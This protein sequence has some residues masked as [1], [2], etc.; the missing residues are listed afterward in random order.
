M[1]VADS[2]MSLAA[3]GMFA[4]KWTQRIETEWIGSL[5]KDRPELKDRLVF[6]RDSMRQAVPDWEVEEGAWQVLTAGLHLPDPDDVHVLAAAIAGHADCL[7]TSNLK[8]FPKELVDSLGIEVLHPDQFIIA[9]WDLDD[10]A[11][12]TAFKAMRARWKNPEATVENFAQAFERG[13]MHAV[14]HRL[15]EASALI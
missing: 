5:E 12:M 9:Q 14:A 7:V 3:A 15:R 2:L 6:R 8:D 1:V 10:V 11:V 13:A 4:A